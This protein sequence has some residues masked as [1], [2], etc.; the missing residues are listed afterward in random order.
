MKFKDYPTPK[1]DSI[2]PIFTEKDACYM[3][4]ES[5]HCPL[6]EC[7]EKADKRIKRVL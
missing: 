6:P 5:Q 4:C 3:R 1:D 2:K 7:R